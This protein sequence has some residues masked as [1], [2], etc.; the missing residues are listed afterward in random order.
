M[1]E[2]IRDISG[3]NLWKEWEKDKDFL[4]LFNSE[5]QGK[6]AVSP[7]RCYI[8]YRLSKDLIEICGDVA[9]VG[10]WKGGISRLLART[11]PQKQVHAF[12]TFEGIPY[13]DPKIDK[14]KKGNGCC[15][16]TTVNEYLKDCSNII[17]HKGVFPASTEDVQ[18]REFSLVHVDTDVYQSTYD[19]IEFFVSRMVV[20]GIMVFDDYQTLAC[21]GVEKALNELLKNQVIKSAPC[22]GL[23][24]KE[25]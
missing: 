25:I 16:Y 3:F 22:Q 19:C 2:L 7:D 12:D 9:E 24:V 20:G 5:I 4:S 23:V 10:V 15:S 14:H 11:S 1:R 21:P 8:L 6:T 17:I 18:E 13:A